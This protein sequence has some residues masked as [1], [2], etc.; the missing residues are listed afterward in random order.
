MMPISLRRR[1][2]RRRACRVGALPPPAAAAARAVDGK[3]DLERHCRLSR[4][5]RL[6]IVGAVV[7]ERRRRRRGRSP[8]AA[9]GGLPGA[10]GPAGDRRPRR[11][12]RDWRRSV[13]AEVG[14]P[15]IVAI[16]RCLPASTAALGLFARPAV[17][18][19][20]DSSRERVQPPRGRAARLLLAGLG[21]GRESPAPGLRAVLPVVA[22]GGGA[23]A[24]RRAATGSPGLLPR[25]IRSC[26]RSQG[27]R[28]AA[29]WAGPSISTE[30]LDISRCWRPGGSSSPTACTVGWCGRSAR[31]SWL[32][33]DETD[34]NE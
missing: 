6:G 8:A 31:I 3:L 7:L 27:E 20:R 14:A 34:P 11:R 25:T 28:L 21:D 26:R 16:A 15:A 9:L 4:P 29:G 18:A 30:P 22:L 12:R 13:A 2:G 19:R 32:L 10:A 17:L 1:G 24:G 23:A 5:P 33:D